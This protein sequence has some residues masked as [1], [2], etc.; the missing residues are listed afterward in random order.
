MCY[1]NCIHWNGG[2]ESC[3]SKHG[4]FDEEDEDDD[5]LDE[6]EYHKEVRKFIH[7]FAPEKYHNTSLDEIPDDAFAKEQVITKHELLERFDNG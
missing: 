5:T 7:T 2:W 4:C 6:E 1:D 3:M